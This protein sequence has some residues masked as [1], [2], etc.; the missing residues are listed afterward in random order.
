MFWD[1][2]TH[3]SFSSDCNASAESMIEAAIG[4]ELLGICFTD[5]MDYNYPATE[6][7][8]VFDPAKREPALQALQEKYQDKIPVLIGI[9][10]GLQPCAIQDNRALIA[11]QEY[12]F[13]IGS[14][15]LVQGYDPYYPEYFEG[16][17]EHEAYLG[18]FESIL[19]NIQTYNDYDVYGHLD[20]I[21]RYGPNKNKN[22]T[23]RE[24]ADVI[25][26]ILRQIVHR[27][28]GIELNTAGL[29]Y[30][31]GHPHP[32]E[33]ILARYHELGGEIITI[34]SDAH[35]P[36]H[37]AYEFRCVPEFLKCAGFDYYTVFRERKPMFV[38]L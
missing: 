27:G 15:H 9:E 30:G 3:T 12:D 8:F 6:Y 23:Y 33:E 10:I 16:K 7:D 26:E 25:D 18:Y 2:H 21:V 34:G 13:V 5:H 32:T 37:I 28:K 19:E 11:S 29:K 35:S 14:S 4:K 17:S 36:E 20:Y 1:T 38:K 22:F 24:Y 31:L